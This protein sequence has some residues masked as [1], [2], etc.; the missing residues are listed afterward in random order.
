MGEKCGKGH[1]RIVG[2][3]MKKESSGLREIEYY[4]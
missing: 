3:K 1:E 4:S 2:G